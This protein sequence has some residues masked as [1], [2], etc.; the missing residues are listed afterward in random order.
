MPRLTVH[1]K[2]GG[3]R[4][5]RFSGRASIGRD[6]S[7]DVQLLDIR[8]SRNHAVIT[9]DPS[10]HY[11]IEDLNSRNGTYLE[12]K[13]ISRAAMQSGCEIRIGDT[14]I[15]FHEETGEVPIWT[16]TVRVDP[17]TLTTDAGAKLSLLDEEKSSKEPEA[18]RRAYR[19]L[20]AMYELGNVLHSVRN[21]AETYEAIADLVIRTTGA[22]QVSVME[23]EENTGELVGKV[24][25]SARGTEER[26]FTYSSTVIDEVLSEGRSLLVPD[27]A[28]D[29]HL[30]EARSIVDFSIRS[31]LCVPLR[32]RKRIFGIIF[33]AH[34]GAAFTFD[35]YQLQLLTAIGL[36]AGIAVENQLLYR[37]LE[38]VFFGTVEA[39][40]N[41]LDAKDR[42]TAGHSRRVAEMSVA[43]ARHIPLPEPHIKNL[44][45]GALL[46]D[47]GKIGILDSIINC[48]GPLSGGQREAI[49]LH[50][51]YGDQILQPLRNL[52]DERAI[53]RHHHERW[54]GAGYPDRLAG[55]EIPMGSR[56]VGAADAIDAMTTDRSYRSRSGT[57]HALGELSR[58]SGAQFDPDV[59]RAVME[60]STAGVLFGGPEHLGS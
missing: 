20:V 54:D 37:K 19:D 1:E 7:N 2:G 47:I 24:T 56:I 9:R 16:A 33:A 42:Y 32:S 26:G 44:R 50:P 22:E 46:H 4:D 43:I 48:E 36:E 52:A 17:A 14:R 6:S 25:R 21:E 60:A 59:V 23:L 45:L 41:A 31:V 5:V 58:C 15:Q 35:S 12:S 28:T 57:E 8:S 13:K 30:R 53:V 29:D 49:Q 18:L 10:G 38:N 55:E 11:F 34:S 39:L 27:T 3:K 51:A 40:V